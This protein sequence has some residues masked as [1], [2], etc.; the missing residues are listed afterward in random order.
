MSTY[1]IYVKKRSYD[2]HEFGN[3]YLVE[4]DDLATA[5]A[6]GTAIVARERD[7]HF[8]SV[9]FLYVRSSDITPNTDVFTTIPLDGTGF[10]E[11]TSQRLPSI[12]TVN[13]KIGVAGGGRPSRKFYHIGAG[14]EQQTDGKWVASYLSLVK[15]DLE[16]MIT[17]V[18]AYDALL[19]D[20]QGSPWTTVV[21]QEQV[22]THQWSK[23]SKRRTI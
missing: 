3:R 1:N 6:A 20:P 19:V 17:D 13:M 8:N 4:A 2:G 12:L 18:Q 23:R 9:T 11:T 14:E 10:R 5:T 7:F 15:G 21:A 16:G 22:G